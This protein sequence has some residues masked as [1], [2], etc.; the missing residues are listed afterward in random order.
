MAYT[1]INKSTDYFNT[2]LYTGNG[3]TQSITGVGFQP[4]FTWIKDRE[5]SDSVQSHALVD[6]VRGAT[7]V[8]VSNSSDGEFT[9]SS[10]LTA[11]NSDG[12]T[13]GNNAQCNRNGANIASWNWKAGG[14]QGSSNTDGSLNTTYTSANTTSGF[15]VISYI[16]DGNGGATLG[17]GMGKKPK[18]YMIK[19]LES[20]ANQWIGY[21]VY[22]N[23]MKYYNNGWSGTN[24][25]ADSAL[26][27]PTTDVFSIHWTAQQN[28]SGTKY[29]AY[30]F[31]EVPGFCKIG[32]YI[33]N[34]NTDGPFIYTGFK[35]ALVMF[36]SGIN[37]SNNWSMRD[38]KRDPFNA[39]KNNLFANLSNSESVSNN[40][41]ILSNGI[42]LRNTGASWNT[43]GATYFYMAIAEAP[44]VGTNNVP[45]T[46]R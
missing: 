16:G 38:T 3:G 22:N 19:N 8:L 34:G 6:A 13:L 31:A 9:G 35:P 10:T 17:H 12:F 11:F 26:A 5:S 33:G 4:D 29:I 15:S 7:K 21:V 1:T 25:W 36:K 45:C 43:N 40:L 32:T 23:A 44:L 30:C 46:A 2:K 24:T 42:K 39:S 41:D 14:G 27:L 20:S 18:F 28:E 37:T